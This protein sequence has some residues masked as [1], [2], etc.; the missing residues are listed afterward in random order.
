[1]FVMADEERTR[2]L[3]EGAGYRDIELEE[4]PVRYAV[5]GIDEYVSRSR[6]TGGMFETVY[7][8]ASAEEQ[9]AIKA[10]LAKRFEPFA[11][12]GGYVLPGVALCVRAS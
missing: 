11:A 7:G 6:E 2:D 1:M 8:G 12:D 9:E 4:V 5:S 10:E 3:V